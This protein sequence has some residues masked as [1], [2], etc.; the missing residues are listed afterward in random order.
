MGTLQT[1]LDRITI[2]RLILAIL[3]VTL[4]FGFAYASLSHWWPDQGII[5]TNNE[6]PTLWSA[7]YFSVVT[8]ATLG[9]GDFRP[10]G[11]ARII[12]CLEVTFGLLAAG[13]FIAKLTS[14][15]SARFRELV[16]AISGTWIDRVSFSDG[17]KIYG[18]TVFTSDGTRFR[19]FGDNFNLQGDYLGFFDAEL[20]DERLPTLSFRYSNH[21][22]DTRYFS[23]G[24]N[25]FNFSEYRQGIYHRY[26]G[27]GRDLDKGETV[28]IEG[29]RLTDASTLERLGNM[30]VRHEQ[31][32]ELIKRFV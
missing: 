2:T 11:V 14:A 5:G 13:M 17:R 25:T 12:A 23:A 19:Y 29:W 16:R 15:P 4:V 10:I 6:P 1:V 28:A 20:I 3:L 31:M 24:I 8:E 27:S 21:D 9:Y 22:S 26:A 30:A 32:L 7:I 18:L